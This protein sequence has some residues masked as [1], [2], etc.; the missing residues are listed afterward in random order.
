MQGG[1]G[2]LI[3]DGNNDIGVWLCSN[4][5]ASM[6]KKVYETEIVATAKN[7]LCCKCACPCGSQEEQRIICVHTLV[8]LYLLTILMMEDLAEHLL[9]ALAAR[10]S[11]AFDSADGDDAEEDEDWMWNMG[12]WSDDEVKKMKENVITLMEAAGETTSQQDVIS[13]SLPE[14]LQAF[15]VGTE[16]RKEWRERSKVPPK[17]SELRPV[18][19]ID[20]MSSAKR[21]KCTMRH[22]GCTNKKG[23]SQHQPDQNEAEEQSESPRQLD[24]NQAE[25]GS[26]SNSSPAAPNHFNCSYPGCQVSEHSPPQTQEVCRVESCSCRVHRLCQA[27]HESDNHWHC[28]ENEMYCFRHHPK[29]PE[30]NYLKVLALMKAAGCDM[31]G[32][33]CIGHRL[34]S[35]RGVEQLNGDFSKQNAA[36]KEAKKEWLQLQ[37]LAEERSINQ[38]KSQRDNLRKKVDDNIQPPSARP[39]SPENNINTATGDHNHL[40]RHNM[41]LP[42]HKKPVPK[43]RK[44]HT[45]CHKNGCTVNSSNCKGM[46]FRKVPVYPAE[47]KGSNIQRSDVIKRY[48]KI[49]L[50]EEVLRCMG[51]PENDRREYRI[52]RKHKYV[53]KVKDKLVVYKGE[54]FTKRFKLVVPEGIW[55]KSSLIPSTSSRGYLVPI[56]RYVELLQS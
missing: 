48:G 27:Q 8:V 55:P 35:A 38:T 20:W 23:K 40:R 7:L 33:K 1:K 26:E 49:L 34:L 10:I 16:R 39:V 22:C 56:V 11:G 9:I 5:P 6:K 52:C 31:D 24:H 17:P 54:E 53:Q 29:N 41:E 43:K 36:E 2:K 30:P 18:H 28:Y 4:I 19:D 12:D 14:L 47:L 25:D 32:V 13:K 37:K 42:M 15:T 44:R 45:K 21:G 46:K 3:L 50:R 51:I